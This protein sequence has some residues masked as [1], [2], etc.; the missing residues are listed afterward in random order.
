VAYFAASTDDVETNTRF[1]ESLA[2]DYPILSSTDMKAANAY[3]VLT[4]N[5]RYAARHTVYIGADGKLLFI[6]R[7]VNPATAGEDVVGNLVK[8]GFPKR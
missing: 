1:A 4:E 3:G 6:D 7:D 8:L 2:L 5:G